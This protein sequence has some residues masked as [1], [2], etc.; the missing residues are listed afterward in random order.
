ML[1]N[2]AQ[3]VSQAEYI[4]NCALKIMSIVNEAQR[5]D[6]SLDT[7]QLEHEEKEIQNR[8]QELGQ[9]FITESDNLFDQDNLHKD[10]HNFGSV[11]VKESVKDQKNLRNLQKQFQWNQVIEVTKRDAGTHRR[12]EVKTTAATSK[13]QQ[14]E[15]E[16]PKPPVKMRDNKLDISDDNGVRR[17]L[18]PTETSNKKIV[19]FEYEVD[20]TKVKDNSS[21]S[22]SKQNKDFVESIQ[23]DKSNRHMRASPSEELGVW[24]IDVPLMTYVALS[25]CFNGLLDFF[26]PEDDSDEETGS[27]A[28]WFGWGKKASKK[29]KT[30]TPR[31]RRIRATS[32]LKLV[33]NE[34]FNIGAR[35]TRSKSK[36]FLNN[37]TITQM[38]RAKSSTGQRTGTDMDSNVITTN[39]GKFQSDLKNNLSRPGTSNEVKTNHSSKPQSNIQSEKK[40]QHLK[41]RKLSNKTSELPPKVIHANLNDLKCVREEN[42]SKKA[43]LYKVDSPYEE[44]LEV[45]QLDTPRRDQKQEI[46]SVSGKVMKNN[47][48]MNTIPVGPFKI[49]EIHDVHDPSHKNNFNRSK[50]S[51]NMHASEAQIQ[52]DI[53]PYFL[54]KRTG[55][56]ESQPQDVKEESKKPSRR[57]QRNKSNDLN[58]KQEQVFIRRNLAVE[59]SNSEANNLPSITQGTLFKNDYTLV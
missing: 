26:L 7:L 17:K 41:K 23:N 25:D 40:E 13:R 50:T 31:S 21:T 27:F 49:L 35:M 14:Q 59:G 58:H 19:P 39:S 56:V 11:V 8:L 15:T 30:I 4:S 57:H 48:L 55:V 6:K 2:N 47:Y 20:N 45:R 42:E 29:P 44:G 51:K 16:F 43:S 33:N 5:I 37:Q 18:F 12:E 34:Y 36:E 9:S 1:T 46:S 28:S 32:Q 54:K 10:R 24:D 53:N 52:N 22:K 3:A 38:L